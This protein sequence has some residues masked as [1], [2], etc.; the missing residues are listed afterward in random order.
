MIFIV[1]QYIVP[2]IKNAMD[3]MDKKQNVLI[4]ERLLKL[5]GMML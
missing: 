2:L 4:L 3:P 1:Q 5:T